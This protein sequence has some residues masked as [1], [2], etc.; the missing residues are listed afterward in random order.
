[1]GRLAHRSLPSA[2]F[3]PRRAIRR[4]IWARRSTGGAIPPQNSAGLQLE[5]EIALLNWMHSEIDLI[6]ADLPSER[7][8]AALPSD[9]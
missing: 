1:M 9:Y 5:K 7:T 8:I 3:C 6:E 2:R 4:A